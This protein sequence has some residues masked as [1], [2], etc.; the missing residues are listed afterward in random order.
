MKKSRFLAILGLASY[1]FLTLKENLASAEI[2]RWLNGL[3]KLGL[4]LLGYFILKSLAILL[5]KRG[6]LEKY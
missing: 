3:G 5:H 2:Y 1:Y 4:F 6:I